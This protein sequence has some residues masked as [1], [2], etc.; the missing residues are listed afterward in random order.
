MEAQISLQAEARHETEVNFAGFVTI[1]EGLTDM[2]QGS[3]GCQRTMGERWEEM[4]FEC[5]ALLM[6]HTEHRGWAA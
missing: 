6:G 4:G 3:L 5:W 1:E 2:V